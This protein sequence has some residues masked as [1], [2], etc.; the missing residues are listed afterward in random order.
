MRLLAFMKLDAETSI[1]LRFFLLFLKK[2]TEFLRLL[3]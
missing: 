2:I 3:H 1:L